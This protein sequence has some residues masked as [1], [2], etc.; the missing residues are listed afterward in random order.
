[1]IDLISRQDAIDIMDRLLKSHPRGFSADFLEGMK[2]GYYR[3]K[4]ELK[5]MPSVNLQESKTGN[6]IPVSESL[7]EDR[8]AVLVWCPQ[9]K[10]IYCAY[11]EKEQWWIFGAISQKV[12]NEVVEW[13]HLPESGKLSEI[14]TASEPQ[15]NEIKFKSIV[16]KLSETMKKYNFDDY[17]KP[18][19]VLV[20]RLDD[21]L[22]TKQLKNQYIN[23]RTE[24]I[25]DLWAFVLQIEDIMKFDYS[26]NNEAYYVCSYYDGRQAPFTV[27]QW[28][29][30]LNVLNNIVDEWINGLEKLESEDEK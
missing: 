1:M 29:G 9:Y 25:T 10:N 19:K 7:P 8:Y 27:L 22:C 20:K 18:V 30:D 28:E 14:P 15:E 2:D 26:M 5:C 11:R 12:P 23:K 3:A 13:M 6:W 17:D 16:K 24:N 4:S 21:A